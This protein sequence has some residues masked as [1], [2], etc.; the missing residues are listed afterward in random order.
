MSA[1]LDRRKFLTHS[2]AAIGGVAMAGTVVDS[3]VAG[4]AD[5]ATGISSVTPKM[6]GTLKVG[7][8]SDVPNYHNFNGAQGKMDASGFCLANALYDALFV[9][10]ANGKTWVPM[11]ALSATPNANYT[12]WTVKLRQGVTFS[13]GDP[14]NAAIVVAN[15]NAAAADPTVGT[16]IRPII[17]K[18]TAADT[19]TVV[20]NLVIPFSTFPISAL[21]EQQTAYMAHPSS[22]VKGYTGN[23]IGTGPFVVSSWQV[24]YQS[25]FKKNKGY[26]RADAHN[27][28]LPYLDA[29]SFH[30]IP[31]DPTRNQALQS[32][33]VDMI[34]TQDGASIAA[35]K[36]MRGISY[37]TDVNDPIDPSVNCLIVNTTGTMNQYFAWAGQFAGAGIPGALSY[38]MQ[39]QA[40]PTQ[41][42]M[43]DWMGTAGAVDPSTLSWN[44]K[45]K[46]V[47]NDVSIRRACAM[48]I[49]RSAYEKVIAGGVGSVADGIYRKSSPYYR[50]PKYP[51][52]NPKAAKALVDAYKKKNGVSKVGFVIDIVS[53]SS[54]EQKLFAF[55]SQQLGAIGIT[56]TPRPSTQSQL[57]Q[58]VI[59]G[60]YD[61]SSWNQFG[62]VDPS[63]NYVWFNSQPATTPLSQGGMGMSALPAGT[64]IAGAVNFAHQA[65][66]VVEGAMLQ[67][68]AAKP[69]SATQRAAWATVNSQFAKDIPYLF[70]NTLITAWAARTNVQNWAY[71]TAGDGTTRCLN[72]DGGSTRWDQIWKK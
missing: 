1:T 33:Q 9:A 40:V 42:Q 2:A 52:Y 54:S 46:P 65:D 22:L 48:A 4:V 62:G 38:L 15:F 41:V 29:I 69:N 45:L 63:L 35:L 51:A 23:P 64:F 21:S 10:A 30:T 57:I 59:L 11:L 56:V 58:N 31:D 53:G 7:L 71:A 14:F 50:N 27:R 13:N 67:A 43:A 25:N 60:E 19:Y 28:Q 24:G 20:F 72:P 47:L 34:L 36:S 16:A 61:C 37:R 17:A 26:W 8:I 66:P 3:L 12:V 49:N 44:V 32:G 68:L 6:G 5:A 55:L 18:V 70:L 39:G